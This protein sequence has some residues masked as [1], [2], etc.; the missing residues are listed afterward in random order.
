RPAPIGL[1]SA[2]APTSPA[3]VRRLSVP[4]PARPNSAAAGLPGADVEAPAALNLPTPA[5]RRGG[6]GGGGGRGGAGGAGGGASGA[7]GG[8][9]GPGAGGGVTGIRGWPPVVRVAP[10]A[11]PVGP[12]APVAP[13]DG[14]TPGPVSPGT[15]A[16]G[17]TGAGAIGCP[18]PADGAAAVRSASLVSA[19]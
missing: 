11:G 3:G 2:G 4:L 13:V 15:S 6:G 5:L 12:V 1:P 8:A 7:G 18:S 9:G 19:A 16:G 17:A 10:V 14:C